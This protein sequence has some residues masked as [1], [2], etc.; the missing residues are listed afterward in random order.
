VN[1][2]Y[3]QLKDICT[4]HNFYPVHGILFDLGLSSLQLEAKDRGFSFRYDSPLDMRF[5]PRE[6]LTAAD[7]V[8]TLSESEL[9]DT[10]FRY[11]EEP[12][13]R[14][15][16]REIV[17]SRPLRTTSDLVAAVLRAT[18]AGWRRIHPATRTF[19]ALR[20]AVNHE[21]HNIEAA[22]GQ[23]ID[24]LGFQGRL[25]VISYHSLEDRVVKSVLRLEARG[26]ICPPQVLRCSCGHE[27]RLRLVYSKAIRPSSAEIELNPRSR[28]ARL[29]AAERIP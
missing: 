3:T 8:N 17:A 7:I 1:D 2:S 16:A 9:A 15:I 11:G 26:C 24:L 23:A 4:K 22:L 27:P 14:Q 21:L 28:S 20:I 12:R 19:Q 6:A 25:V 10:I 18:G 13:S 29:R 5:D